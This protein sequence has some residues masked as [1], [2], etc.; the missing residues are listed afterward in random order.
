MGSSLVLAAQ[1][2]MNIAMTLHRINGMQLVGLTM[3]EQLVE[4]DAYQARETLNEIDR[5]T[6]PGSMPRPPRLPRRA[7]RRKSNLVRRISG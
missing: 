4:I 2:I 7:R 5:R 6:R 3:F 1:T